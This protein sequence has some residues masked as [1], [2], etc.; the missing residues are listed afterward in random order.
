MEKIKI[1]KG[2]VLHKKGD[3]VKNIEIV[4]SGALTMTNRDTV[5][6]RLSGGGIAGAVY[7]PG[8]LYV[9]DYAA[10]EDTTLLVFDYTSDD[11]IVDAVSSATAIAP[12]MAASNMEFANGMLDALNS[13]TDTAANFCKEIKY[14]YNDYKFM[15]VKLE[16]EPEQFSFVEQLP[17]P[18][19]PEITS[20]W[21]AEICRSF[22]EHRGALEANYYSLGTSFCIEAVMRASA[23]GRR[24]RKELE[25][26]T[27]FFSWAKNGT[28]D[29]VNAFYDV[30][31]R[32]DTENRGTSGEVPTIENA[33]EVI[34]A[35]SGVS[36]EIA[37]TFRKDL[38]QFSETEDR[39]AKSDEM[40]H[41]RMSI[42]EGYYNIYEAAFFKSLET[43]HIPAEVRMFFLFGFVDE[44]LAGKANT[45]ML[46]NMAVSWEEPEGTR[47]L[48]MYEWLVRI[49]KGEAVP[50][51]NEFDND[52]TEYLRE[53][54]RTANMTQQRADEL[55]NDRHAMVSFEIHNMFVTANKITNGQMASFVPVFNAQDVIRPLDKCLA[56]IQR[57]QAALDKVTEI[58][59]GCFYRPALIQYP[60]LKIQHFVYNTEIK[61]YIILMPNF[62]ARGVMWQENEGPRRTTPAHMV[63]SIFHSEELEETIVRMCAQ[64][65]WEMCRRIQ[66]VRYMDISEPSLTSEYMNY[67][68]FYKKNGYLSADMKERI[69]IALQKARNDYKVV[70][71]ADYEKYILN[72]AFGLPRLN[73][74]TR[75]ILFRYCTFSQKY[76]KALA[77]NPQYQQLIERWGI[78][79]SAKVHGVDLMAKKVK[80][81]KPGEP[82]PKEI[83]EE[84]AFLRL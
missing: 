71:V 30:K 4:L 66:G 57:V 8:D 18:D 50:S 63:I 53:E 43:S 74:V 14:N 48:P 58:D 45:E 51:K 40:R 7:N 2:E 77:I 79:Q 19:T 24:I 5:D 73:K 41:L 20:S 72:E 83:E 23:T 56:S 34:L 42:A 80:R 10:A 81:M 60:E 13:V 49:Y 33:L 17:T 69:K 12:V 76:R 1:G 11:D 16:K 84:L 35:F 52:W 37:D 39:R 36:Q 44:N 47:I 61:P 46:Y 32:V 27:E 59:F 15:C 70:F 9:F 75:E 28:A 6:V 3:E 22:C 65:R 29:F 62:G 82:L 64:F 55:A 25:A 78:T 68:Q 26:A 31:S 67:L 21:E 38:K 54:V